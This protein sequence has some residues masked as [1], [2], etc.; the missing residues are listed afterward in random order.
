MA[1]AV[2]DDP[3]RFVEAIRKSGFDIY[4][5]I[6]VGDPTYWIPATE[7]ETLLDEGMRGVS[8]KQLPN[9]TRSKVIKTH[10]CHSLGYPVPARFVKT[11]PRFFGQQFDTY[12]QK[13]DNLQI[14][15][16][17]ISPAR[18]YV[19]IRINTNDVIAKV[20]VVT[21][22]ALAPLDTTGTL[23][24]KYQASYVPIQDPCEL[25]ADEDTALLKPFTTPKVA[26]SNIAGPLEYPK[27]SELLAIKSIFEQLKS[28]VGRTFNDTSSDRNRGAALH[29]LICEA[30]GYTSY[31]DDGEFPDIRHQLLEV[32]LQ[33]SR[34]IDLGLIPPNST[35][36]L[37]MP[38]I[39]GKQIRPCDTRY[40]IFYAVTDGKTVKLTHLLLTTGERFFS[41]LPQFGGKIL[42]KKIQLHLPRDFF[43]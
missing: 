2:S 8:L 36:V 27:E 32:K 18:R 42:N 3:K 5:P 12:G 24:Q 20:K 21:G 13:H 38:M 14:W 4:S 26:L 41:R 34:T 16:E 33:T 9:R 29:R 35:D 37:D 19:L 30:L 10:V 28:L 15:N 17:E 22:A 43:A 40:A 39:G 7:L 6:K 31:Q 11:Q 1:V 23:T 25:V